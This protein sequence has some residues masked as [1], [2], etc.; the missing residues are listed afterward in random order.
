MHEPLRLFEEVGDGTEATSNVETTAPLPLL[1]SLRAA[2]EAA[3]VLA[4]AQV[5]LSAA[6]SNARAAGLSWRRIGTA[7]GVPYQT[8]HRRFFE[9]AG[10]EVVARKL[11]ARP[12]KERRGYDT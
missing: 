12:K 10:P 11:S 8:L 6:V 9:Q 4:E 1:Q 2:S 5:R 3:R 7:T